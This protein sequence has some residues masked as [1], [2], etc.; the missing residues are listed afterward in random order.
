MKR[1][2]VLTSSRADYGIY[3]PLLQ[4]LSH[5]QDYMLELIVFGT[6]LSKIHGHTI[7][8]IKR[9][10][11]DVRY[12][13]DSQLADDT[14][15]GVASSMARTMADFSDFWASNK[16][17]FDLVFAL[18]DR[19][20]MF[21]AVYASTTFGIRIAHI[22]G[23]ETTLGAI[24]NIF[25]HAISHASDLHFVSTDTYARRVAQLTK[26]D[27]IFKVGALSL[28]GFEQ[29]Q[30]LDK[31][32]MLARW[33]IDFDLPTILIT[34]NPETKSYDKNSS[35]SLIFSSTLE[36]LS[37]DYQLVITM[38]NAD[39]N[40]SIYRAVFQKLASQYPERIVLVENFGR[41]SYFSAMKWCKLLLGNTSSGII[42]AASFGKYVIDVG[43]RQKGRM[44]SENTFHVSFDKGQIIA[45]VGDLLGRGV[46][47]GENVYFQE[48]PSLKIMNVLDQSL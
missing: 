29:M 8:Q 40:G 6:H 27:Q 21:S 12:K 1:I 13:I 45:L 35:H 7:D 16:D 24:D 41:Q 4:R 30:L 31:N 47:N 33:K 19:F 10:G 28:D 2:G 48:S 9:D 26:S 5:S 25:R 22:H 44:T 20:E 36:E 34:V 11:F 39:T 46:Y 37:K 43:D 18:G 23:G 42:E 32:Q 3:L 15:H 14:P 17:N 38:P